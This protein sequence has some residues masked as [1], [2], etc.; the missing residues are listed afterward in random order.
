MARAK[1][2]GKT[3]MLHARA[4]LEARG[5]TRFQNA[6]KRV[7]RTPAGKLFTAAEDLF[8]VFDVI[9]VGP[10]KWTMFVQVTTQSGSTSTA[11]TRMKKIEEGFL[12]GVSI[13]APVGG[14]SVR[15]EVWA[16]VRNSGFRVWRWIH[17]LG[18]WRALPPLYSPLI[19]RPRPL[20]TPEN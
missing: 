20:P 7:V 6:G 1:S 13:G 2:S 8:G 5:Y 3:A 14:L 16:W 11:R 9:A 12:E 15:V 17:E 4:V 18:A 19:K 10:A